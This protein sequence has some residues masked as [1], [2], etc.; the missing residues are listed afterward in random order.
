MEENKKHFWKS[1]EF[2]VGIS[3]TT[4]AICSLVFTISESRRSREHDRRSSMPRLD[5]SF[6]YNE[7]SAGYNLFNSGLGAA[8][9]EWFQVFVD[10]KP[11]AYWRSMT[12]QVGINPAGP[13]PYRFTVPSRGH[14]MQVGSNNEIFKVKNLSDIKRMI[15][16]SGRIEMKGCYCSIYEECWIFSRSPFELE[17]V[18]SCKP[19]PEILLTAPSLRNTK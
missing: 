18:S 2:W 14:W 19:R 3:A 13:P 16:A 11:Q 10:G 5:V 8:R 17:K 4:I 7:D 9:L 1:V 12:E 15:Q 6:Y